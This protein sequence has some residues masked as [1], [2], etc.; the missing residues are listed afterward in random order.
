MRNRILYYALKY[1][2]EYK[3]ISEAILNDEEYKTVHYKGSYIT[4]VD[5][6]YPPC[7]FRLKYK[8][9]ILF[10]KGDLNLLNQRLV[11][12]IGSREC[13][14]YGKY[15][16]YDLIMN[17]NVEYGII[18]GLAKGIDSYSHL[19][20]LNSNRKTIAVIGCGIDYIYPKENKELY[21]RI[22][23]EGLILSE[24]PYD[25]KP[26]AFHFPWRNRIIASLCESLVVVE[27][28]KRS[29]TLITVNEALE[30][31]KDIYCFPHPFNCEIGEGCNILIEQGSAIIKDFNDIREI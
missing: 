2:G 15:C 13:S 8:P 28:K 14:E 11:G 1:D 24:Y 6:Q 5:E 17:L 25:T 19:Y 23:K 7:L 27:A 29:G 9:W 20:S 10:Y 12:V 30:L 16:V 4:I 26:Y 22:E 31:G 3:K 21:E 18:S